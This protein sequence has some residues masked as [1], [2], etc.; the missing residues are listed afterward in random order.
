[1][2]LG[3]LLLLAG[4]PRAPFVLGFVMGPI[5]ERALGRTVEI[6]GFDALA[7]PGVIVLGVLLIVVLFRLKRPRAAPAD[8]AFSPFAARLAFAFLM[9]LATASFAAAISYPGT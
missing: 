2:L 7:R 1:S 5:V 3:V 8:D 9:L 6:F 4:L